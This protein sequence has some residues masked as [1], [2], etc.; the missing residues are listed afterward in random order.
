MCRGV[1]VVD[2]CKGTNAVDMCIGVN[3]VD[4]C[5]GRNVSIILPSYW[6][7]ELFAARIKS[8][9]ILPDRQTSTAVLCPIDCLHVNLF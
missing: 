3:V 1:N 9:V 5:K 8:Y 4:I 2:I 7:G 6:R